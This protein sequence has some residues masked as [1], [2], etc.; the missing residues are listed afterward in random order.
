MILDEVIA[1]E[2]RLKR[3]SQLNAQEFK[4]VIS[5]VGS[6]AL[7]GGE[8]VV[9]ALVE[10]L[11]SPLSFDI[12]D[13]NESER[14]YPIRDAARTALTLMGRNPGIDGS[15]DASINTTQSS[16]FEIKS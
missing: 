5:L 4:L 2:K 15:E 8:D 9:A 13:G 7:V 6:L 1:E 16:R 12:V 10:R 3:R 14:F 11:E